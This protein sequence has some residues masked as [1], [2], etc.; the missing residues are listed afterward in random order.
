MKTL[1][2][3][4]CHRLARVLAV[5]VLR[6]VDDH[7]PE[8]VPEQESGPEDDQGEHFAVGANPDLQLEAVVAVR[9]ERPGCATCVAREERAI[10]RWVEQHPRGVL[11]PWGADEAVWPRA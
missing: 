1:F 3:R 7:E 11:V 8:P 10:L 9:C 5:T 6:L 2:A 4:L